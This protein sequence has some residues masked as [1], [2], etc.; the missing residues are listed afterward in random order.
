MRFPKTGN[1]AKSVKTPVKKLLTKYG[2]FWFS[3]PAN[4]F[5]ISGVADILAV[6][7]G[8]FMAIET[9]YGKNDPTEIQLAFL[10]SIREQD[11]F[12]FVV[13]DSTILQFGQFLTYLNLSVEIASK[14]GTPDSSVGGPLL[15]AIKGLQETEVLDR[16]RFLRM[17]RRRAKHDDKT[18]VGAD[19]GTASAGDPNVQPDEA[20]EG[21]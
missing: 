19:P 4:Q 2:W 9:K 20:S 16:A 7:S 17:A 5:G 10:N 21:E 3:P 14:G 6:K 1:E 8:M 11:H 15:D 13:R 12:A 18:G